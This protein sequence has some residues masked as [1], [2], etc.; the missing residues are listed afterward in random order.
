MSFCLQVLGNI[1]GMFLV[2]RIGRRKILI[3]ASIQTLIAELTLGIVFAL[4]VS[5]GEETLTGTP[6]IASIV[7]VGSFLASAPYHNWVSCIKK[8]LVHDH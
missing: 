4:S 8:W 2:D 6:A 5:A 3:Q 7:L 1:I